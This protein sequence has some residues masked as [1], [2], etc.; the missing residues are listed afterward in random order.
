MMDKPQLE[1]AKSVD[2]GAKLSPFIDT[3]TFFWGSFASVSI[4]MFY[5]VHRALSREKFQINLRNHRAPVAIA[6]KALIG[7]TLLC[8]GTFA[9][10][11]SI[12][13][14]TTGITSIPQFGKA[15]R[16]AFTRIDHLQPVSEA[17]V[18]DSERIKGMS[19]NQE[20]D[21]FTKEYFSSEEPESATAIKK[22]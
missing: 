13:I 1:V 12:F 10:V 19:E 5:G 16:S 7:G 20:L 2:D 9:G 17:A 11:M 18:R 6:S 14:A 8:F 3:T 15:V 21:Y 22:R 4:G